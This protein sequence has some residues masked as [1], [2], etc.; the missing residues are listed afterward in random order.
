MQRQRPR[1][2]PYPA[3]LA[4]VP[5][6]ARVLEAGC[7]AGRFLLEAAVR[8]DGVTGCGFDADAGAIAMAQRVAQRG[9][10]S[11]VR[12]ETRAVADGF[13]DGTWEVVAMIDLLHHLPVAER[14]GAVRAAASRVAPAG[15]LIYKDMCR[16]P[17]WR[18]L[19]NWLHD[20]VAARQWIRHAD[21][22]DV[23]RWAAESGLR[24][25]HSA[26]IN[27]WWYGHD[28]RVFTRPA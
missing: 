25:Q 5:R 2:C 23:E 8:G 3:L 4:H 14:E 18:A 28:L 7:G 13:P 22:S 11:G 20:L 24:L 17:R 16:Y 9:R 19:L 21:V 1:I 26:R 10:L 15:C 12:F 6:G 27:R